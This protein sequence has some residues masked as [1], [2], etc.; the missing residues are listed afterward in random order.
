MCLSPFL[1][2]L[3]WS[4]HLLLPQS[5]CIWYAYICLN[6]ICICLAI[7]ISHD[8]QFCD[9]SFNLSIVLAFGLLALRSICHPCPAVQG[10]CV[11]GS[12]PVPPDNLPSV[13]DGKAG[14]TE[15]GVFVP[16]ALCLRQHLWQQPLYSYPTCSLGPPWLHHR[17]VGP[18]SRAL[19]LPSSFVLL[20]GGWKKLP[21]DADLWV[22]SLPT[23]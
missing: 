19:A 5:V 17:L 2:A 6:Y 7:M 3:S 12:W 18:G 4:F 15:A 16:P 1:L 13:G 23:G 22:S 11:T 21:A 10:C 14:E 20:A 9:L 8:T